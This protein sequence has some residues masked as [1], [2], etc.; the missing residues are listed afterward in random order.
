MSNEIIYDAIIVGAG[1]SGLS[2]ANQLAKNDKKV[3]VIEKCD[4]VGGCV[5]T[6]TYEDFFVELG[7]HT[8]YN[9]YENFIE[10]ISE[11]NSKEGVIGRKKQSYKILDKQKLNSLF[12]QLKVFELLSH[13]PKLAF[14][15]KENKTL[16]EFYSKILGSR[17]FKQLVKPM[18]DAVI[19]Q[20]STGF[21]AKY[22]LNSKSKKDKN[23]P[24]SFTFEHGM[25]Q[26]AKTILAEKYEILSDTS[27]KDIT[28]N[29]DHYILNTDKGSFKS[30]S[31][32]LACPSSIASS[33][34]VKLNNTLSK[35]LG[36]IK[37]SEINS[38]SIVCNKAD[39]SIEEFAGIIPKNDIFYSITSR[40]TVPHTKYRGF[41]IHYN[42]T[43]QRSD[44]IKKLKEITKV[45]DE[46][47]VAIFDANH[48]LPKLQ[49]GHGELITKIDEE[50]KKLPNLYITGNYF[51]GTSMEHCISRSK[52]EISR[53]LNK[54]NK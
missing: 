22:F 29:K 53:F 1:I 32:V 5:N 25:S 34:V 33:L 47:I 12:S 26:F 19:S 50:L 2:F 42:P 40:D 28:K 45:K 35:S 24:K 54:T 3:L 15:N 16:E 27:V 14:I 18:F 20:D 10:L 8:A 4:K 51:T 6:A 38:L 31:C 43:H 23:F 7:A 46:H 49:K 36:E 30:K 41:T 48:S 13:L 17:N 39:T 11:N 21:S 9:S 52:E 44:I 37:N